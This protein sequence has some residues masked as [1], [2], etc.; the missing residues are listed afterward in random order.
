MTSEG[1]LAREAD[2]LQMGLVQVEVDF[3]LHAARYWFAT[4][5][6]RRTHLPLHD[7]F[8]GFF[9]QT[10]SG[11][12]DHYRLAHAAVGGDQHIKQYGPLVFGFAGL[13]GIVKAGAVDALRL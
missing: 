3:D 9:F 11:T 12:F 6:K 2:Q 5:T 8:D 4:R 10:H 7:A 13:F 1:Y